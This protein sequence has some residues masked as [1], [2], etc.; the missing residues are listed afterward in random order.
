MRLLGI[1][2]DSVSP[3][4]PL[5]VT[6]FEIFMATVARLDQNQN[7]IHQSFY[8]DVYTTRQIRCYRVVTW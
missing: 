8:S 4:R 2:E 3:S 6:Y 1:S 7:E 5:W